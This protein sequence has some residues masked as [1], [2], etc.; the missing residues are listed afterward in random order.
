[1]V[2]AQPV[3]LNK[4]LFIE[5]HPAFWIIVDFHHPALYSIGIELFVPRGVERV[6]EIDALAV[7]ADLNHLRSA[8]ERLPGFL[9]MSCAANDA[10]EV[11]RPN[12]LRAGG[13]RHV[14]LDEF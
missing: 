7:A 1:L 4:E 5:F 10:T 12:L 13:I 14:V 2:C 6:S 11:G 9:R 8:I 3:E